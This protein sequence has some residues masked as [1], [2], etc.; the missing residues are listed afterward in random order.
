MLAPVPVQKGGTIILFGPSQTSHGVWEVYNV[1]G[2]RVSSMA[3][4]SGT[5][6]WDTQAVSPGIY[7]VHVKATYEQGSGGELWQKVVVVR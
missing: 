2:Q 1:A 6:S 3:F 7:L 5:Q 4:G